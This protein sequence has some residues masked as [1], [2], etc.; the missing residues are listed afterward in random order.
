[1]NRLLVLIGILIVGA[2]VATQSPIKSYELGQAAVDGV[3]LPTLRTLVP[4]DVLMDPKGGRI[5]VALEITNRATSSG[6]ITDV[7]SIYKW[8]RPYYQPIRCGEYY[9]PELCQIGITEIFL[10]RRSKVPVVD[11]TAEVYV[12]IMAM[13]LDQ[14][15]MDRLIRVIFPETLG[16]LLGFHAQVV[17]ETQG[18]GGFIQTYENPPIFQGLGR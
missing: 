16:E 3:E 17:Q 1:M 14:T 18:T 5:A 11:G 7:M 6:I 10:L 13:G 12:L 2:V 8:S 9:P 15:Q 4:V